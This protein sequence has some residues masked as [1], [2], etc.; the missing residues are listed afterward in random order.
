M[1]YGK[2]S[3]EDLSE[4]YERQAESRRLTYY[5]KFEDEEEIIVDNL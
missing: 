3:E 2:F 4:L 5:C 1:K